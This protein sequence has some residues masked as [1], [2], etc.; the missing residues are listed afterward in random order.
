MSTGALQL[1]LCIHAA[2]QGVYSSHFTG[3]ILVNFW[4]SCRSCDHTVYCVRA[5]YHSE[6][7]CEYDGGSSS[8]RVSCTY[9]LGYGSASKKPQEAVQ[10][11]NVYGI[12]R[13]SLFGFWKYVHIV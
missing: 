6:Q 12:F 9:P 4:D 3:Q 10:K 5:E 8:V 13:F 2:V 11:T 1:R 7:G